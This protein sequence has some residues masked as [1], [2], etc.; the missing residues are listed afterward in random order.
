ME[1]TQCGIEIK[2]DTFIQLDQLGRDGVLYD[3]LDVIYK[4][5]S[6]VENKDKADSRKAVIVGGVAGF[7]GGASTVITYLLSKLFIP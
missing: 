2:K 4:R 7:F 3:Y 6:T 1:G 5:I